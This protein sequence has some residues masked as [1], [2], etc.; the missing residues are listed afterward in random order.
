MARDGTWAASGAS[1]LRWSVPSRATSLPAVTG[2][3]RASAVTALLALAIAGCGGKSTTTTVKAPTFPKPPTQKQLA[4][5]PGLDDVKR[6]L[7]RAGL[8]PAEVDLSV[9]ELDAIETRHVDTIQFPDARSLDTYTSFLKS[10]F[11]ARP[12]GMIMRR[13]GN[14]LYW[15]GD[16]HP[17]TAAQLRNF[18]RIVALGQGS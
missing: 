15:T 6:R 14:R 2:N 8:F 10:F 18:H 17:L 12:T 5:R 13:F 11:R 1:R 7:R 9:N 4:A 16:E 3:T